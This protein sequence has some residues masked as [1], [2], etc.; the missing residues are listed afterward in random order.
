MSAFL[1]FVTG[2]G[3]TPK[4]IAPLLQLRFGQWRV[5]LKGSL[6]TLSNNLVLVH[7]LNSLV[8]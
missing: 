5:I 1:Y 6:D 7:N 4:L 3:L 8:L 2:S